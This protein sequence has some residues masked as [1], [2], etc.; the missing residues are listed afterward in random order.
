MKTTVQIDSPF[1]AN[2]DPRVVQHAVQC[3]VQRVRPNASFT[4]NVTITDNATLKQLNYQYRGINA[5]TDV[6]SFE[7][8][9]DPDFPVVDPTMAQYLGDIVIAYPVAL[10]QAQ[11]A[12]HTLLDEIILLTIHGTLHLLGYNHDTMTHKKEMWAVQRQI[13]NELGLA[14]VNPTEE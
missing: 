9:T 3:T 10:T 1:E 7:H 14:H 12:R 13:L 2:V 6:L 5:P 11:A 4:I 8:T